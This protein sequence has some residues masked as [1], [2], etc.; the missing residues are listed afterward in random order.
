[1][2][3]RG[4]DWRKREHDRLQAKFAKLAE[5][6]PFVK[7]VLKRRG[8]DL[9]FY[10]FYDSYAGEYAKL[11]E[12]APGEFPSL[13]GVFEVEDDVYYSTDQAHHPAGL[14]HIMWHCPGDADGYGVSRDS[15]SNVNGFVDAFHNP[16][17]ELKTR[18]MLRKSVPNTKPH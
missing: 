10:E 6:G 4:P 7:R 3:K 11:V 8:I 14:K 18:I 12:R 17:G 16:E 13:I 1:M 9:P 15:D 2:P 5:Q